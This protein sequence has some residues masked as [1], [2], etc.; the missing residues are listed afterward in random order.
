MIREALFPDDPYSLTP[1]ERACDMSDMSDGES[2]ETSSDSEAPDSQ[3]SLAESRRD[4]AI[5]RIISWTTAWVDCRL[6]VLA[7]H[8]H[9]ACGE[10]PGGSFR[11][12]AETHETTNGASGASKTWT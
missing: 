10:G 5:D 2:F 3:R 9:G 11:P 6:A 8:T 1:E 12:Q 4:M 7:F